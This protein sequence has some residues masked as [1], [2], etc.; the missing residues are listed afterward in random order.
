MI[1]PTPTPPHRRWSI[2]V[3]RSIRPRRFCQAMA[4]AGLW[5]CQGAST[6]LAAPTQEDVFR[7][8]HR[9]VTT[10]PDSG[11]LI[12]VLFGGAAVAILLVLVS[13]RAKREATPKAL[14]HQGKLLKEIQKSLPLRTAEIKR[15]KTLAEQKQCSSP[16]LLLLCPSLLPHRNAGKVK[17]G[18]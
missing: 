6:L 11:K 9:N 16:L 18:K 12:A 4:W 15:L 14:N 2:T 13:M 17:S 10:G 5:L 3:Q 7:S 1:A 8:I